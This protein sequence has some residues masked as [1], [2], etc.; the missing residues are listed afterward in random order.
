M[1]RGASHA[2][3]K[4]DHYTAEKCPLIRP[5]FTPLDAAEKEIESGTSDW[6]PTPVAWCQQPTGV[7]R[8]RRRE[9]CTG[10]GQCRSSVPG[11]TRRGCQGKRYR[12]PFT[13]QVLE[14]P[15]ARGWFFLSRDG[16]YS[17]PGTHPSLRR[18]GLPPAARGRGAPRQPGMVLWALSSRPADEES[19]HHPKEINQV[20]AKRRPVAFL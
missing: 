4:L 2:S 12:T 19:R 1:L 6:A 15:Q 3:S 10:P 18:G 5:P 9:R 8:W 20:A 13:R 14:F 17:G 7:S 16:Q 11:A